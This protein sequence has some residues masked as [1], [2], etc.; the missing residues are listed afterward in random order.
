[1]ISILSK[2]STA[3]KAWWKAFG[4]AKPLPPLVDQEGN[5]LPPPTPEEARK[6][7]RSALTEKVADGWTIEIENELDAVVSKKPTFR[8]IG[9]LFLFLLLLLLFAPLA[10]FYLIIIIVQGVTAKPRRIRIL[11]DGDGRIQRH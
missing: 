11:I 4:T 5:I 2:I 3:L 10:A 6:A 9:K 1:M 7:F 8:W